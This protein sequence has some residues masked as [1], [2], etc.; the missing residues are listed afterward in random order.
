MNDFSGWTSVE[1]PDPDTDPSC[2]FNSTT[3]NC[4]VCCMMDTLYNITSWIF[5]IIAV[6]SM[7]MIF[8]GAYNIMTAAGNASQLNAG[9]NYI[10]Y[11]M[12][13]M[14]LALL[15]RSIPNIVQAMLNIY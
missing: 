9:R 12:I 13:G 10:L 11:A 15:A 4:A 5:G 6:L 3:Y 8:Y 7:V 1:C 2:P 14:A